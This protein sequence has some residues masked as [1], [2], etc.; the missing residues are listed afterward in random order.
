MS[1]FVTLASFWCTACRCCWW[2]WLIAVVI[3]LLQLII[4]IMTYCDNVCSEVKIVKQMPT[5]TEGRKPTIAIITSKYYEKLAVDSMME[6]KTTFVRYKTEGLSFVLIL[7]YHYVWFFVCFFSKHQVF[8]SSQGGRIYILA[9]KTTWEC[10]Q[11]ERDLFIFLFCWIS[12]L[13]F[14]FREKIQFVVVVALVVFVYS[15]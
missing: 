1:L 8:L 13:L 6:D 2:G 12:I 15:Q 11:K 9:Q 4:I 3:L 7:L 10:W 5:Q 14:Y